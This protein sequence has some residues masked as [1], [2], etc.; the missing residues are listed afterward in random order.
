MKEDTIMQ[1]GCF[2]KKKVFLGNKKEFMKDKRHESRKEKPSRSINQLRRGD[3][4]KVE[5]KIQR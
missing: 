5:Q 4:Q 3:F 1:T 2:K